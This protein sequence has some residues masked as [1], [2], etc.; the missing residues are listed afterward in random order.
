MLQAYTRYSARDF[1]F[2]ASDG[3]TLTAT[4]ART[5][6]VSPGFACKALP[7]GA[8]P[9]RGGRVPFKSGG[10]VSGFVA[11]TEENEEADL[12]TATE[13]LEAALEALRRAQQV[14]TGGPAWSG[15]AWDAGEARRALDEAEERL[16]V[17][18]DLLERASR[19]R[20]L[21]NGAS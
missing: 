4:L 1:S 18:R 7:W 6:H 20:R 9:P 16:R 15:R 19:A 8:P 21:R 14:W 5:N 10:A 17:A 3:Q 13:E 11:G 2:Y 12:R